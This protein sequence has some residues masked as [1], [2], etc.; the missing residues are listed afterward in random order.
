MT[1][2]DPVQRRRMV[3]SVRTAPAGPT[4][5]QV[6]RQPGTRRSRG[7]E[8]LAAVHRLDAVLDEA[9]R[10]ELARWA[11]E[12]YRA[13]LDDMPVG[14]VAQCF[15]G[16]P[17][18]D[19]RMDLLHEILDH[20]APADVMPDPFG[21]ARMLVRTGAYAF[22]EVYASGALVPVRDDGSTVT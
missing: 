5:R 3:A 9:A 8:L 7:R 21:Q 17:F 20:Y 10:A 16:P 2:R 13:E 22:V 6:P 14:L 19:H 12:H 11:R 4:E 15:L 1:F 18:V